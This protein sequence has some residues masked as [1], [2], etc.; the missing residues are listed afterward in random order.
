MTTLHIISFSVVVG[1]FFESSTVISSCHSSECS[2]SYSKKKN[3]VKRLDR[4]ITIAYEF[5][6]NNSIARIFIKKNLHHRRVS[7]VVGLLL[8]SLT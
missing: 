6:D 1:F 3:M 4:S 2:R 5:Y 7:V 8:T